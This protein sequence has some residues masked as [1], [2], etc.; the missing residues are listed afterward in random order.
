MNSYFI[1]IRLDLKPNEKDK[2]ISG[3]YNK[4]TKSYMQ[5]SFFEKLSLDI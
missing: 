4:F 1:P 2:G 5:G 3:I